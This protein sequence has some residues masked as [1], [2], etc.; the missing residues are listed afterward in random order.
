MNTKLYHLLAALVAGIWGT[1]FVSTKVL[2]LDGFDPAQIFLL[3]FAMAY[4][5]LLL[6]SLYKARMGGE[7]R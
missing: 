7:Q 4:V 6:F 5:L 2:L 1:T 3:R